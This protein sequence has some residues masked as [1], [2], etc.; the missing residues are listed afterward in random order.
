M[1]NQIKT[2]RE[3]QTAS[4]AWRAPEVGQRRVLWCF[5]AGPPRIF[6]IAIK[7]NWADKLLIIFYQG[8]FQTLERHTPSEES[9]HHISY[10]LLWKSVC[11]GQEL[12]SPGVQWNRRCFKGQ[13]QDF[14]KL[15]QSSLEH[16]HAISYTTPEIDF[17]IFSAANIWP[18]VQHSLCFDR[19]SIVV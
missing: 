10:Q 14:G 4:D 8:P 19:R 11:V 5:T 17:I 18:F 13:R 6:S 15:L 1:H 16:V 9:P 12:I 2:A 7:Q 3:V